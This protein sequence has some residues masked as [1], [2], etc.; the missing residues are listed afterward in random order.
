MSTISEQQQPV[1]DKKIN[2]DQSP[3]PQLLM[4]EEVND[5]DIKTPDSVSS[6]ESFLRKERLCKAPKVL[7]YLAFLLS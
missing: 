7:S 1:S 4:D 2:Q 6:E 5:E 3:Q